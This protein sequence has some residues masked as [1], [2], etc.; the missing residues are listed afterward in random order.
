MWPNLIPPS[1]CHAILLLITIDITIYVTISENPYPPCIMDFLNYPLWEILVWSK[2]F[3][4]PLWHSRKLVK[5]VKSVSQ[6]RQPNPLVNPSDDQVHQLVS[7]SVKLVNQS[8]VRRSYHFFLI[9]VNIFYFCF[10]GSL[11]CQK[12]DPM[13]SDLPVRQSVTYFSRNWFIIFF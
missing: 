11:A 8:S 3:K 10:F 12:K 2:M 5:S 1:L 9:L 6:V 4:S 7:Q 13:N